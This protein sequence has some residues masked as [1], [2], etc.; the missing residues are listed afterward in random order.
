MCVDASGAALQLTCAEQ[1][2]GRKGQDDGAAPREVGV[3]LRRRWLRADMSA[4][5]LRL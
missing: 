1:R 5:W 4:S 2:V 3:S